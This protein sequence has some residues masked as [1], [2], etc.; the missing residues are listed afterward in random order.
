MIFELYVCRGEDTE[1]AGL[2]SSPKHALTAFTEYAVELADMSR[3]RLP[4][5]FPVA[6]GIVWTDDRKEAWMEYSY[7]R[8]WLSTVPVVGMTGPTTPGGW[9]TVLADLRNVLSRAVIEMSGNEAPWFTAG[10]SYVLELEEPTTEKKVEK[11][12]RKHL[13]DDDAIPSAVEA[14]SRYLKP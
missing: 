9:A 10:A 7:R 3:R 6:A 2:Y 4:D 8:V 1:S 14:I 13:G 5:E 12:L 11:L